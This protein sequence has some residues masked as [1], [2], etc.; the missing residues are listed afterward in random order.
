MAVINLTKIQV[1]SGYQ[2][3]LPSLDT[4][5]FG[6][7]I[8]TQRLFIG[9]GTLAEGA[10][11]LGVTEVLTEY[12]IDL[13]NVTVDNINANVANLAASFGVITSIIGNAV[14]VSEIIYD[15]QS[16]IVPVVGIQINNLASQYINYNIRRDTAIRTG[17]ISVANYGGL[18]VAYSDEYTENRDTG[19]TL[20]VRGNAALGNATLGYTS[21]FTGF[22]GTLTYNF[23][24][25]Q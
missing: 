25:L 9:K 19:V 17:T 2:E 12:S 18:Q 21:S 11:E 22:N 10:P 3:D 4:G 7:C 24:N 13:I 8:D 23:T 16:D 5:E 6:W 15:D 20:V 1:R 14:P